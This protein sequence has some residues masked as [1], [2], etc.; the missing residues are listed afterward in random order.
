MSERRADLL[1]VSW[2]GTG[3]GE[4]LRA[5]LEHAITHGA[6]LVFLAILDR[7]TFDDVEPVLLGA[8]TEEL[9]WLLDAQLRLS[10]AQLGDP[11]LVT[12]IVVRAGDVEDVVV[13]VVETTGATEVLIGAP[14]VPPA[15]GG[16]RE[17]GVADLVHDLELRT[18][19]P[20][21]LVGVEAGR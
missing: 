19:V 12:R 21:Q 15:V 8:I 2:G 1:Y 14:V 9:E 20:V 6:N 10:L 17:A 13:D 18:K 5:A 7:R 16:D 11:D 3:R 4:S